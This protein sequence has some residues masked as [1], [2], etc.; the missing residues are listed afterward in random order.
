MKKAE[1][2]QKIEDIKGFINENY[3]GVDQ[4]ILIAKMQGIE[5][6]VSRGK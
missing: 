2:L 1:A 6:V 4:D 3:E 5:E